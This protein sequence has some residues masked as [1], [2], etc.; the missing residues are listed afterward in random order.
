MRGTGR[1]LS[2]RLARLKPPFHDLSVENRIN[3]DDLER[4]ANDFHRMLSSTYNRHGNITSILQRF[5]EP[6]WCFELLSII[7]NSYCIKTTKCHSPLTSEI[8]F[9]IREITSLSPQERLGLGSFLEH[10]RFPTF[11]Y[12]IVATRNWDLSSH[13]NALSNEIR[14]CQC[15]VAHTG[16]AM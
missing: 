13:R 11:V 4:Q 16:S 8:P 12:D 5:A 3:A 14:C 15:R 7:H 10:E 2:K 1:K 9:K 6:L